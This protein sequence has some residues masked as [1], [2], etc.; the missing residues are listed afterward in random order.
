MLRKRIKKPKRPIVHH[1]VE[2]KRHHK[3]ILGSFTSLILALMISLSIFTYMIFIKQE[4]NH[5]VLDRKI[6]DLREDTH[7]SIYSLSEGLMQTRENI[8]EIGSQMGIIHEEFSFIKASAGEGFSGI[9]EEAIPS[10]VTIRTDVGQGTGFIIHEE[11]YVVT[12]AHVLT[13]GRYVDA[14]TYE[15]EIIRANFIGYD[16][17]LD[18]ALLKI[19]GIYKILKLEE[20]KNIQVGESVIAIGNPL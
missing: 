11:G 8:E 19:P 7:S 17:N 1:H 18:I 14:I 20:S 12:N 4:I 15:Q 2:I 13:D 16:P 5:N 3:W 10:I 6:T 9:I